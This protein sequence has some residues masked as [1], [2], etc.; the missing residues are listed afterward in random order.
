MI[1]YLKN[2]YAPPNL[3][4]KNK[5]TLRLKATKYEIIDDVLFKNNYDSI[6]L[7]CLENTK[8]KEEL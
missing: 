4:Y 1:F 7:R 2:G 6:L 8:A 3:S 5:R